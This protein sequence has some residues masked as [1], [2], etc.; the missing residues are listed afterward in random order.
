MEKGRQTKLNIA[1][2]AR[3]MINQKG[4]AGTSIDEIIVAAGVTKGGFYHHY[5]DKQS[6]CIEVLRLTH[7]E[8]AELISDCRNYESALEAF[9]NFFSRVLEYHRSKKFVGGCLFGNT[10]LEMADSSPKLS[11]EVDKT[12]KMWQKGFS[13]I[14]KKGQKN[15][16][17]SNAFAPDEIALMMIEMLE[18]A[19]MLSRLRKS[20]KPFKTSIGNIK[21]LFFFNDKQY[22]IEINLKE[23]D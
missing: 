13:E 22:K 11:A 21:K 14:I 15:R 10:A 12:F 23:K 1:I 5:N 19:L 3:E 8:F 4:M 2:V 20:E 6:L 16:E 17:I 9:E 7:D 18:G